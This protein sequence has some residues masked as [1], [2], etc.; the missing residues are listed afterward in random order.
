METC[1]EEKS[2][3]CATCGPGEVGARA[4]AG[5]RVV[6]VRGYAEYAGGHIAGSVLLPLESL[7]AGAAGLDRSREIL[8]VCRSGRRAREAARVLGA[9]GFERLTVL[10]GGIEACR[11]EGLPLERLP[12][13]PWAI[14]RQVRLVAGIMALAGALLA[15]FVHPGWIWLSGCVGI[16]LAHAAITDSCMMG[17]L[18]ALL[19]WNKIRHSK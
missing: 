12:S 10:D 8:L 16:G 6:D 19:P 11:R 18:M 17:N 5:C 15:H 7:G 14:D 3:G 9:M 4:G 1:C 13:A 2:A